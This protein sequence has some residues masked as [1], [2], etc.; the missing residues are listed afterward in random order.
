MNNQQYK[1]Y[2]ADCHFFN[3]QGKMFVLKP[4]SYATKTSRF[5][6]VYEV[7]H[8]LQPSTWIHRKTYTITSSLS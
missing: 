7:V 3:G 5:I 4:S 1:Q 8:L 6:N 2:I